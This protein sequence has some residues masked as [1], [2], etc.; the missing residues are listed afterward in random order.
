M[1]IK[2]STAEA[3]YDL[4]YDDLSWR[5]REIVLFTSQIDKVGAEFQKALLRS[6]V[7]LLYA[8]WEGFVKNACT[9][10]LGFLATKRLT[11][12]QLRPELAALSIR[13]KMTNATL[14]RKTSVHA[15]IVREIRERASERARIPTNNDAIRTESN[16]SFPVLAEILSAVG[17]DSE[18]YSKYADLVDEQLVFSRNKIAHGEYSFIKRT[19]WDDLSYDVLWMMD[20]IA[21]QII[22]SAVEETYYAWKA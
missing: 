12:Q 15:E 9:Y 16:L 14:A 11:M 20:D 10:Y 4:I 8:H 7:A 17:C 18:R 13:G 2:A 1:T 3:L 22:N 5:R 19:E 6:S 21:T